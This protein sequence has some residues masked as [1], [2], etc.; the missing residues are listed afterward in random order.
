MKKRGIK[1]AGNKDIL[2]IFVRYLILVLFGAF[3]SVFYKVFLP[4]TIW[5]VYFLLKFFYEIAIYGNLFD[6]AGVKIEIINACVAGSAYYL[7]LILNL[8]TKMKLRKRALSLLFSFLA[9]LILNI[10]RISVLSVFY[11][12]NFSFF[13]ITHKIF[14]YALS[15]FFVVGIWFLTVK[16]FR[17]KE[18]PVYSDVNK[19]IKYIK[20]QY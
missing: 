10:A 14:W 2:C 4:L 16:L 19:L 18:V 17:I 15:V 5:P 8:T 11:L 7:L 20:R 12:E 3:I 13:D 1:Q 6:I 9:L